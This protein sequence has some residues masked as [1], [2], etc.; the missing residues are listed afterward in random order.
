[1]FRE[2]SLAQN[3]S[4]WQQ[5]ISV[6]SSKQLQVGQEHREFKYKQATAINLQIN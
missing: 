6:D 5:V 3:S 1:M 2:T 4:I